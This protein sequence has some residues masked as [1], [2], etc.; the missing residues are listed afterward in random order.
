MLKNQKPCENEAICD[1]T[2]SE[3]P[4]FNIFEEPDCIHTADTG[5]SCTVDLDNKAFTINGVTHLKLDVD[6]ILQDMSFC[7]AGATRAIPK[8]PS[9]FQHDVS[10]VL[11]LWPKPSFDTVTAERRYRNLRPLEVALTEWGAPTWESLSVAQALPLSL[12]KSIIKEYRH[13][14]AYPYLSGTQAIIG[15]FCWQI[16]CTI[17][18]STPIYRAGNPQDLGCRYNEDPTLFRS[19]RACLLTSP[20]YFK[21]SQ[22]Y[23]YWFRG[24]LVTFCTRLDGPE[25]LM[26]EVAS[27]TE[28]IRK[29]G[30][31]DGVG[32]IISSWQVVAVAVDEAL[33]VRHSPALNFHNDRE[34]LGDGALL[35]AH[36]LSPALTTPKVP[37]HPSPRVSCNHSMILPVEI[38]QQIVS[39][40]DFSTYL[41]FRRVS[42][43]IREICLSKPRIG[44]H[45]VLAA[46]IL[47][48]IDSSDTFKVQS[49]SSS[50]NAP[51]VA[52]PRFTINPIDLLYDI[53]WE[54][55]ELR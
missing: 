55:V 18:P 43:T 13:H 28:N 38:M 27:M 42:K 11:D 32:I 52:F 49:T 12:V 33:G 29:K 46:Q 24:C 51:A 7:P 19:F 16:M 35:L 26:H 54:M 5:L 50:F 48:G 39:F 17:A 9:T 8:R 30:R 25:Y 53:T 6:K 47:T 20:T 14:L 15:K 10:K 37:W 21:R 4:G 34:E 22:K 2:F 40:A 23:Y 3:T 44:N 36:L 1:E 31:T 41:C 45:T